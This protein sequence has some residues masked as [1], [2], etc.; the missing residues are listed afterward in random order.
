MTTV[1]AQDRFAHPV[2][3]LPLG[4]SVDIALSTSASTATANPVSTGVSVVRLVAD[5]DCWVAI[6]PDP[7]AASGGA[8]FLAG[9]SECFA[10][11]PGDKV[12][13]RAMMVSGTLNVVEMG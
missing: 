10:V 3:A 2:P 1:L 12:A 13:G 9:F 8:R 7:V 11:Q 5:V 4:A 6:G